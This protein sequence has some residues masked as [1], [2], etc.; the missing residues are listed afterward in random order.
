MGGGQPERAADLIQVQRLGL[1]AFADD[2]QAL[3]R[4]ALRRLAMKVAGLLAFLRLVV[5]PHVPACRSVR[6]GQAAAAW[7]R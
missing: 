7:S 3:E 2:E 5:A 6:H 4:L 1:L